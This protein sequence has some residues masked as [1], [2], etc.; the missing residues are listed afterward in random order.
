MLISMVIIV[1]VVKAKWQTQAALV[2]L[3]YEKLDR[4]DTMRSQ[5]ASF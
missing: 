4:I 3:A 5:C 1:S 2:F